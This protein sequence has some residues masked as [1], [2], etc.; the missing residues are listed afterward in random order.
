[1]RKRKKLRF[2]CFNFIAERFSNGRD[3]PPDHGYVGICGTDIRAQTLPRGL[4]YK[5]KAPAPFNCPVD[6]RIHVNRFQY[7]PKVKVQGE[8]MPDEC[9]IST[10]ERQGSS[11]L[12]APDYPVAH[13]T[14]P[15]A[16]RQ[17]VPTE[18]LSA[19]KCLVK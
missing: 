2:T 15:A 4:P 17:A 8:I 12:Q 9:L 16:I 10:F 11:F 19:S 3:P 5:T 13:N 7:R 18:N 1:M 14:A 6:E